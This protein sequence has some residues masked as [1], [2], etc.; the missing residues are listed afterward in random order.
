[1]AIY[2]N[3]GKYKL[4]D[5][6]K[7]IGITLICVFSVL[8]INLLFGIIP[9]INKFF[10]GFF[11]LFSYAIFIAMIIYGVLLIKH[12]KIN[13]NKVDVILLVLWLFFFMCILHLATSSKLFSTYGQYL[14]DVY[15]HKYTAGGLL[16]GLFVYPIYYMT[17]TLASYI[18]FIIA[19]VIV[20][21]FLIDRVVTNKQVKKATI[22]KSQ[23]L[24]EEEEELTTSNL[25]ENAE[26]PKPKYD[27]DIFVSD[28]YAIKNDI[29][30][31]TVKEKDKDKAR[32]ILG[33]SNT[34]DE[35]QEDDIEENTN[36]NQPFNFSTAQK[37]GMN[38]TQYIQTPYNPFENSEVESIN[39][40]RRS[41]VVHDDDFDIEESN[42]TIIKETPKNKEVSESKRKALEFLQATKGKYKP[43]DDDIEERQE[44]ET[45]DIYD[46]NFSMEDYK[47]NREKYN[48][49]NNS[50]NNNNTFMFDLSSD[51]DEEEEEIEEFD[52]NGIDAEEVDYRSFTAPTK[53]SPQRPY[54]METKTE[55]VRPKTYVQVDINE[56]SRKAEKPKKLP[57]PAKYI[58]PDTSIL[59]DYGNSSNIDQERLR[60][61]GQK[62]EE[63]LESFRIPAK[64]TNIIV[65]PA[66]TRYE[67]QMPPGISVNKINPL[68]DNIAMA[69]EAYGNIRTEIPIPGK[70]AF[71]IEVPNEKITTVGLREILESSNFIDSKKPLT[72]AL[73]KDIGGECRISAINDAPHMLIAGSTGSG[74]SVCLNAM[75]IS[76][77]FKA[78]PE[79]VRIIL[80]DPKQ[81]EFT[82]YNGL[83]HLL[84]PK[85]ITAPDKALDAMCWCV[86][87]MERRFSLFA[88]FKVRDIKEYNNLEEVK[89]R[90]QE[91]MPYIILVVDELA[92]LMTNNKKEF[93]E[94]INKLAAKCRAA[95]IHLVL[96]TQ[97]PSV[98]VVTGT[99]KNNL[100]SRI[101]FAVS[102]VN[103]SRTI[104][105]EGG[106]ENLLGKGDM[107]FALQGK[108]MSRIQG[109]FITN[110]EVNDII[111]FVKENNEA[112]FDDEIEDKMFNRNQ[113]VGGFEAEPTAE[114]FD[115]L[116]KEALRNIIKSNNVSV[117]KLQRMFSIGF[118]RAG[119]MVDQMEAAG[120]VSAKDNKN[121]R[122]IFITQQEFEEKFGEDL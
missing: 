74:K 24:N 41:F 26:L 106:A 22:S 36:P 112:Y 122:V 58:A 28:D 77:L 55:V 119:R 53:S 56:V 85:V 114:M 10:L 109:A 32:K 6:S 11:G 7:I 60:Y 93:E 35:N 40:G 104:L 61:K 27:D 117:S 99:I 59:R 82:L 100:P 38:K 5:I 72:Y 113:G 111:E 120:Y 47:G 12:K 17:Y 57:K 103:D 71:G 3:K 20:S 30:E 64:I 84:I 73:G 8:L 4:R 66:F 18:I 9:F 2:S 14:S 83:P 115:P 98:D 121:N 49:A 81:V 16:I 107:L 90:I 13:I 33:L 95:G 39:N 96:A 79:D 50:I 101:A 46:K 52:F 19:L 15:N 43:L 76:L 102:S 75:L 48:K 89:T 21:A 65:G 68:I 87:E 69:L 91:K 92:D 105:G 78:T 1:M 97:R 70:N 94:K 37:R 86:D 34:P 116:M 51:D 108:P 80:I 25:E 54:T 31:Q 118:N 45:F 88:Q 23:I 63:T 42:T 110:E 62:L 44:K 67:L 29:V